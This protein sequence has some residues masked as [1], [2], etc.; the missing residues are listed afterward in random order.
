MRKLLLA[1]A[2]LTGTALASS[3]LA[4]VVRPVQCHLQRGDTI[5]D[6]VCDFL[7]YGGGSFGITTFV[8]GR[9][10]GEERTRPSK[11]AMHY[12]S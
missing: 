1:A 9:P 4:G 5:V 10:Q 7:P 2:A 12:V 6:G 11:E 3:A 8:P